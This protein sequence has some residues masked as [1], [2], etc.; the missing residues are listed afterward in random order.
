METT[1]KQPRD[2]IRIAVV[3]P[4]S[5]GKSTLSEQLATHFSTVWVR[6]FAREYLERKNGKY[7][8]EDLLTIAKGQ[9]A[10]EIK[11]EKSAS[12]IIICDTDLITI[13]IWSEYKYGTCDPWITK[14]IRNRKYHLHLLCSPD[15]PWEADPLR[16][17]PND[18]NHL[19]NLY[20]NELIAN[21]FPFVEIKGE[22]TMRLQTA[23]AAV[24][25]II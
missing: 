8:K 18:R 2:I 11:L 25:K 24:E 5:T 19:H 16:E 3:G 21:D 7:A 22:K 17:N 10:A 20:K 1:I 14:K 12:C 23:I 4:E 13:K 9:V 6:E 15:I